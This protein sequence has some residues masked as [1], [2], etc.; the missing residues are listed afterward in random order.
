MNEAAQRSGHSLNIVEMKIFFICQ[1][2]FLE[3]FE[4]LHKLMQN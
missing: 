2:F 1:D 4:F 3:S